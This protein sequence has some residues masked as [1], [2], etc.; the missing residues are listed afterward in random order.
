M[1]HT[2]A[3]AII[4]AIKAM[5]SYD[6]PQTFF[7]SEIRECYT[8]EELIE[9]FGWKSEGVPNTPAEAVEAVKYRNELRDGVY[10]WII[11]EGDRERGGEY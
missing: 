3:L 4:K 7:E 11:E 1:E 10:G 9:S 5:P 8:D 2:E 6:D